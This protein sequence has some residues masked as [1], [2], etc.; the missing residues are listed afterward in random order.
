MKQLILTCGKFKL[1]VFCIMIMTGFTAC[2]SSSQVPGLPVIPNDDKALPAAIL[3]GTYYVDAENGDDNHSGLSVSTAWKT[4][5]HINKQT[6]GAGAQVLFKAGQ[7]WYG[8][9]QPSGSGEAGRPVT[10][11][12]YGEG[13]QPAIHGQGVANAVHLK[14]TAYLVLRDLEIDASADIVQRRPAPDGEL[15]PPVLDLPYGEA[16]VS[17]SHHG[18]LVMTTMHLDTSVERYLKHWQDRPTL[19]D[20][21]RIFFLPAN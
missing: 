17:L 9:L 5:E 16:P 7:N 4:L 13:P 19:R 12:R 21:R 14:N 3:T 10:I 2:S 20:G 6:F 1:P 8:S 11:G 15:L 18:R